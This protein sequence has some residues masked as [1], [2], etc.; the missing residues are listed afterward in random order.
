MLGTLTLLASLLVTAGVALASAEEGDE[1]TAAPAA[2]GLITSPVA[3]AF[4]GQNS[5][6]VTGTKDAGSSVTVTVAGAAGCAA[7]GADLTLTTWSCTTAVPNGDGIT[8]GVTEAR[9]DSST[10]SGVVV[11]DV[12]G[13]PTIDATPSQTA[14]GVA[15]GGGVDGAAISLLIAG[16]VQD[17]HAVVTGGRWLCTIANGPG[18]YYTVTA[19]QAGAKGTSDAS[20]PVTLQVNPAPPVGPPAVTPPPAQPAPILPAPAPPA[21]AQE[22][23]KPSPSPTPTDR[24]D[25][26]TIPWLDRPI[27]PG[28]EGGP[29]LREALTNWGTPTEFGA[30]L[31]SPRDTVNGGNWAWGPVI[32]LAFIGLVALPLRLLVTSLRGRLALRAP[33]LTGR[34]RRPKAA[35]PTD[36]QPRNPWLMGAVPLAATA[37]LIVLAQG[38]N[39][40]VRYLRLLFAVSLGLAIL[41]TVGVAVASRF[42]AT[43]LGV[44]GRLRFLPVLLLAAAIATLLARVTGIEPP[45]VGGVLIGTGFALAIPAR[46]RAL[47]NLAQVGAVLL[48]ALVAWFGHSALGAVHGFWASVAVETLAT[49]CLAGLGSALI[50]MLPLGALPGRVVLE[51]SPPVWVASTVAVGTVVAA[52]L[53]GRNQ[54]ALPLLVSALIVAGFAAASVAVWAWANYLQASRV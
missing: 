53:L 25:A 24:A 49:V 36:A 17:C 37:G 6:T 43:R 20:Q 35:A 16:T 22:Q 51:W 30:H 48:L 45:L 29:T 14:P 52:V 33:Q 18:T 50:L 41:N 4:I 1:G 39:G 5:V 21:P 26:P 44:G 42:A 32:A 9:A 40:E 11:V 47:V 3:G 10:A 31:P 15:S 34:N 12:L 8:I 27:F 7:P 28:P 13:P 19:H 46:S 54:P 2:A 23:P 38:M